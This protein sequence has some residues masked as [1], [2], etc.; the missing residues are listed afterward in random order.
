MTLRFR[1]CVLAGVLLLLGIATS[2]QDRPI[3]IRA[4]TVLDGKGGVLDNV[5]IRRRAMKPRR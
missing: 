2:A 5:A 1:D 3:V 4:S